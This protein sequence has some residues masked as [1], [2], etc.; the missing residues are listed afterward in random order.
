MAFSIGGH[1]L[2]SLHTAFNWLIHTHRPN[3][4]NTTLTTDTDMAYKNALKA[5]GRTGP[6]IMCG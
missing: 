2:S 3:D 5:A 6:Y 4:V 1:G